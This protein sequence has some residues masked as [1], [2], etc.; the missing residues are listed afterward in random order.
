MK[1]LI[2]LFATAT[3]AAVIGITALLAG[4]GSA[5]AGPMMPPK[6]GDVNMDGSTNSIDALHILF[7]DAGLVMPAGFSAGWM[8][9]ADVNCDLVVDALDASIILQVDAG[10]TTIRP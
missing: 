5:S 1:S 3:L 4:S 7:Y 8:A 9:A 6:T 10:L 2:L